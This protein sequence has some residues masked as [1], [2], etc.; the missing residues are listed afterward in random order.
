MED[1]FDAFKGLIFAHDN[2]IVQLLHDE[3][4]S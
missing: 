4:C 2:A 3:D 1:D